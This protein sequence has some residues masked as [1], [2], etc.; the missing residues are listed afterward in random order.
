MQS[1]RERRFVGPRRGQLLF[2][3]SFL[4]LSAVLLSL[5]GQQTAWVKKTSFFAQPRFW[6]AVG[7]GGMVLFTALHLWRLPFRRIER[8]DLREALRWGAGLE[9]ALWFM[10]YVMLVPWVGY[11]PMTMIFV[12][13]LARRMGYRRPRMMAIS[14]GFAV[15]TV[16]VFK[17]LLAV[18]IPG[19]LLYEYLPDGLRSFAILYL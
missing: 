1:E 14:F 8:A 9:F 6:P 15:L 4:M 17:G 19:A 7:V 16:L 10:G 2:I 5:I 18:R 3:L 13:L 12:P 11:L